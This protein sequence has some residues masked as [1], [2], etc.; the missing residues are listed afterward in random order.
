MSK[1]NIFVI[2]LSMLLVLNISSCAV[3]GGVSETSSQIETTEET[4]S[5]TCDSLTSSSVYTTDETSSVLPHSDNTTE[6]EVLSTPEPTPASVISSSTSASSVID[7]D[8]V[9]SE[10]T[11]EKTYTYSKPTIITPTASGKVV[12]KNDA[13]T[14]DASNAAD[15]YIMV[16]LNKTVTNALRIKMTSP[17]G[18]DYIF[19]LKG[20]CGYEVIPI[21]EGNGTYSIKI[22]K[23]TTG[24]KASV[25]FSESVSLSVKNSFAPYLL[26]NQYCNYNK[27]TLCVNIAAEFCGDST[28]LEKLGLIYEYVIS[29]ISYDRE[30]ADSVSSGYLP[31]LDATINKKKGICFDYAS[32]MTAMLRSQEIPAKVVVG[33]SG[34]AYHAWISVYIKNIG[35]IDGAIYFDGNSWKRM[36]PTYAASASGSSYKDMLKYIGDGDNYTAKFY[37]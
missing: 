35:W 10:T 4:D 27:D 20:N 22:L 15:G 30:L 16:K 18:I 28:D 9:T 14:I 21:S 8:E 36:D 13:A 29:N 34:A 32:V 23:Q 37:Y 19:Q 31:D 2:L 11:T 6:S 7:T 25:L 1:K 33:Y 17:T 26:P 3:T 5:I 12:Y 24:N